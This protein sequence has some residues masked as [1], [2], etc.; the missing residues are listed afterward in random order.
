MYALYIYMCFFFPTWLKL[1]TAQGRQPEFDWEVQFR[2]T[3]V[4][5]LARWHPC[6]PNISGSWKLK[7]FTLRISSRCHSS[8]TWSV[9]FSRSD[10]ERP[11]LVVGIRTRPMYAMVCPILQTGYWSWWRSHHCSWFRCFIQFLQFLTLSN[12]PTNSVLQFRG[13]LVDS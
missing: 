6:F 4:V 9:R 8:H 7:L 12:N 2:A 5:F 3:K 1:Q 13:H 11:Y 10:R